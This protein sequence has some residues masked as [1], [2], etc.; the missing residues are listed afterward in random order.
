MISFLEISRK[1]ELTVGERKINDFLG[2]GGREK[3][4][5]DFKEIMRSDA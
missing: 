5:R 1:C 3:T 2:T 4:R